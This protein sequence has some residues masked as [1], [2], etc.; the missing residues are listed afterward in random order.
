[1]P[2]VARLTGIVLVTALVSCSNT[3]KLPNISSVLLDSTGQNGR[4]CIKANDIRGYGV[5]EQDVISIDARNRYYLAT[6]L[7]GCIDLASSS[8]AMFGSRSYEVCG[9]GM[10]Q[11]QTG[12]DNCT[13]RHIFEFD[14]REAAFAAHDSAVKARKAAADNTE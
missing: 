13:I 6:V 3:A 7:P 8:R 1:M 5:L 10:G 4:A 14:N 2:S 9:G 11:V 12:G